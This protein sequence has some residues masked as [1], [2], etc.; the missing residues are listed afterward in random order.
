[1]VILQQMLGPCRSN[2]RFE[3][4]HPQRVTMTQQEMNCFETCCS[5]WNSAADSAYEPK[6]LA[7]VSSSAAWVNR[8]S[9]T[10]TRLS[11]AVLVLADAT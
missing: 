10:T 8:M 4:Q 3:E 2:L 6:V 11:I 9:S 5:P 1:V 7:E